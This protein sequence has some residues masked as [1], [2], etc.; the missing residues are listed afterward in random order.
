MESFLGVNL[1][2]EDTY[3]LIRLLLSL[4][5]KVRREG[6]LS[7]DEFKTDNKILQEMVNLLIN[8]FDTDVSLR[9]LGNLFY[10]TKCNRIEHLHH[11]L[12]IDTYR[13]IQENIQ[14]S[15]L[16]IILLSHLGPDCIAT[17]VTD[18]DGILDYEI[19]PL[20][21]FKPFELRKIFNSYKLFDSRK[22]GQLLED[23]IMRLDD[24]SIQKIVE[25]ATEQTICEVLYHAR[26]DVIEVI[27]R[28]LPVVKANSFIEQVIYEAPYDQ[29]SAENSILILLNIIYSLLHEGKIQ[30]RTDLVVLV[31]DDE[32]AQFR[33]DFS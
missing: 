14:P 17:N 3:S 16:R 1:H 5:I 13:G 33:K 31:E 12:I 7:L 25:R 29:V 22:N 32:D 26:V 8:G 18:Y 21:K 19:S 24:S 20:L 28:N 9:I 4:S 30:F 2:K 11:R 10:A 23:H 15:I 6:I 27:L